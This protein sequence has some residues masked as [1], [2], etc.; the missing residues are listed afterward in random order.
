MSDNISVTWEMVGHDWT[1]VWTRDRPPHLNDENFCSAQAD[2]PANQPDDESNNLDT[3]IEHGFQDM[4]IDGSPNADYYPPSL[5]DGHSDSTLTGNT[6]QDHNN[7]KDRSHVLHYI[8]SNPLGLSQNL[9]TTEALHALDYGN[10]NHAYPG[11][12]STWCQDGY[13]FAGA[14]ATRLNDSM[15]IPQRPK[16]YAAETTTSSTQSSTSHHTHFDHSAENVSGAGGLFDETVA[17]PQTLEVVE[18]IMDEM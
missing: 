10:T 6:V 8:L 13:M 1:D 18:I 9:L 15:M 3:G 14:P 12:L 4:A 17:P 2:G 7:I 5:G 16:S 11:N